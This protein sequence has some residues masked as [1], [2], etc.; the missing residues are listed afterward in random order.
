MF[1]IHL[2]LGFRTI[3]FYEGL[4]FLIAIII[5]VTY[6]RSRIKKY[7]LLS[8]N[9]D[10]LIFW[11]LL[12]AIAGARLFHVFFYNI[13][14]FLNNPLSLLA[15][16][17]GGV[18]IIGGL[19]G[20]FL[21]GWI[22]SKRKGIDFHRIFSLLSPVILLS[23]AIG[24]IGCFLNGDA[25]GT[26]TSLPWGVRFP[27]FGRFFPSMKVFRGIES[28]PWRYAK[29]NDMITDITA[30]TA[31]PMHPT[32][33]YEMGG[34][35]VIMIGIIFLYRFLVNKKK[36]LKAVFFTHTGAYALM[37]FF[38]NF[39]RADAMPITEPQHVAMQVLLLLWAVYAIGKLVYE[40]GLKSRLAK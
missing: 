21:V 33:L 4:Y 28:I 12:G 25:H 9:T 35:I 2:D 24:R 23:Q 17:E 36:D 39:I 6:G 22:Y 13:E 5:G 11:S 38:L 10:S 27:R 8:D 7:G 14:K 3:P 31:P 30:N 26:L 29:R 34:D 20:A 32:Q 1:P 40:Y 15:F 19:A 16:W 18:S 37:R